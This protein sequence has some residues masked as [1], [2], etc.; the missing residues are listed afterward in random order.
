MYVLFSCQLL[1]HIR[2]CRCVYMYIHRYFYLKSIYC[3]FVFKIDHLTLKN[4]SR[5]TASILGFT[6]FPVVLY[7]EFIPSGCFSVPFHM[8][9][10]VDLIKLI[11]DHS[12]FMNV[13]VYTLMWVASIIS[14][15]Q[16]WYY[17]KR[18]FY[19]LKPFT[20]SSE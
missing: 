17:S 1:L 14:H 4:Q 20:I 7:G 11:F 10:F 5:R 18:I 16:P 3:Y 19:L 9:G 6:Q 12:Y 8:F 13:W 15:K 2:A